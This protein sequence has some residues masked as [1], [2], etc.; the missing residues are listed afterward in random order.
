MYGLP[1]DADL[2]FFLGREIF[3]V[4]IGPHQVILRF[5]DRISINSSSTMEVSVGGATVRSDDPRLLGP[6]LIQLLTEAVSDV[7][8]S[9]DGT[10][11]LIFVGGGSLQLEDDASPFESYEIQ[12][13]ADLIVV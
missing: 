10:L 7:R 6:V 4:C 1:E 9:T 13:G 12:H 8:W 2:T 3:Q 5:D 11:Q